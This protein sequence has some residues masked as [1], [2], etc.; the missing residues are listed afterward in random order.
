MVKRN[1]CL[2]PKEEKSLRSSAAEAA[3]LFVRNP[4]GI[5]STYPVTFS[6]SFLLPLHKPPVCTTVSSNADKDGGFSR[7]TGYESSPTAKAMD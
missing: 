1:V 2:L 3:D 7:S 6:R 5:E 4:C